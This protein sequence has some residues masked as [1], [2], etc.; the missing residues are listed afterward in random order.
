MD[1][2]P[3]M[4]QNPF[5]EL[6][7][8]ATADQVVFTGRPNGATVVTA[9]RLEGTIVYGVTGEKVGCIEDLMIDKVSG[10]VAYAVL[11]FGGF[12]GMG[13]RHHPLPW[14]I[15]KYDLVKSG[16]VVELDKAILKDAPS[17]GS[18][19]DVSWADEGWGRRVHDYYKAKP[20]WASAQ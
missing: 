15:L 3:V 9:R 20:Y 19:D 10:K 1:R 16:Y 5:A 2:D 8:K 18:S 6:S 7:D 4:D 13:E 12:L 17:F 14:S 11:A